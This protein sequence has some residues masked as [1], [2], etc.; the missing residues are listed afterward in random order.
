MT[1]RVH[2]EATSPAHATLTDVTGP[3]PALRRA[4]ARGPWHLLLG[5]VAPYKPLVAATLA[6]LVFDMAGMLFV[7]TELAAMVNSAVSLAGSDVLLAHGA[8]MLAAA[9]VG[10]GGA[11]VAN[12][13][14]ARLAARVGR[15]LRV[16]VYGA[17]LSFS[18]ADFERFGTGSMV[19]RTLSDANVVQQALLMGIVMVL[20]V[21]VMCAIAVGL[22]FSIDA[23]MGWVLLSVTLAMLGVSAV[24][25]RR[26][27]PIF[28]RLQGFVDRMNTRL[29]ETITGVRVIR[30]FGREAQARERLDDTFESYASNAI[31]VNMLFATADSLTF[32]LANGVE[33][34]VLWLG[35]NRVGA[36]AM[37]IGSVTALI[38]Y[39]MLIMFFMMM[40]QFAI[41]QVPRAVVCLA[42]A[43]EVLALRPQVEDPAV[44]E[45]LGPGS[46]G[47]EPGAAG[48]G[49][50]EPSVAEPGTDEPVAAERGASELVAVPGQDRAEPAAS[51][52]VARFRHASLRFSDA[53][54]DTLH[55][56]DF[57]LARGTRTAIIGNTGSGKSTVAKLLLRFHDVTSGSVE[58][59]GHDVQRIAQGELRARIA[60]VPQRAWLFSGTIAQN[61][62]H[63]NPD[64]SDERLWHALE[65]AQGGF[66]RELPQGLESRVAQGG[67]NFS[68]G[69]RQRLAI[70]RALV[71]RAD[72][73]VF[74]DSF[75]ALDFKTDAA[76]RHALAPEL[77]GAASLVIAQ[78][79]S[80]IRDADQIVV[81][82]EGAVAGIGTHDELVRDCATYQRIVESQERRG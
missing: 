74:D 42:R 48:R 38:E 27:A 7:P 15:D 82:D 45:S 9:L 8:A 33:S 35:A 3:S 30:A 57:T 51:L 37:Q 31:R 65:A 23:W 76:L 2:L 1:G 71:R 75:S 80:S 46:C 73:Y 60:Y 56:L 81:L 61:L 28:S 32:F 24:A 66:V 44:P 77:A 63:G 21:P 14:A 53:D 13:L 52:P 59:C 6:A 79:V 70:A 39:A 19:T 64:A 41:L 72:L 50:D 20:P 18:G 11:L 47:C 17:S 5:L 4:A 43:A 40:A 58:F 34:L 25:V 62:R 10:S 69:Q 67:T 29:R 55:D 36:G 12:L 49:A 54:E 68:G 26:A 22:A 78:R 16:A